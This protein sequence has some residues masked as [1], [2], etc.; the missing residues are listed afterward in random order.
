MNARDRTHDGDIPVGYTAAIED[1]EELARSDIGSINQLARLSVVRVE[2][3][4]EAGEHV[5]AMSEQRHLGPQLARK[6]VFV[7]LTQ[8]LTQC[9][10][11]QNITIDIP[12]KRISRKST[13]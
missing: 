2:V 11:D 6:D 7:H 8:Y 9:V 13:N 4:G 3:V 10:L 1:V 5:L 12:I